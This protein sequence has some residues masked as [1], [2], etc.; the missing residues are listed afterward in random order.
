MDADRW[1]RIDELLGAAMDLAPEDRGRFLAQGCGDDH[2]LRSEVEKLLTAHE[3]AGK[4]I[5][6]SAMKVAARAVAGETLHTRTRKMVG[7]YRIVS[8]L[9]AGGM[10]EVYLAEDTRLN[11]RIALKILPFP[12]VADLDRVRRFEME[13]RAAS[14]L[15]H[16]NIVTIYDV[17]E[18]DSI[19]YIATEYVDGE[20][21]RTRLNSRRLSLTEAIKVGL[22]ITEALT[23]AHE[24]GI[25]HRDVKPENI[26]LRSDGYLKVLDFGLAKLTVEQSGS[27][28]P[29]VETQSGQVFGTIKYMSPEQALGQLVNHRTDLWSTGV[30][31][32]E[33][34]TGKT[35]FSGATQAATFD[36]I[37]N[38]QP[39]PASELNSTLPAALDSIISRSLEK[40]PELR[41]QTAADLRAD[42]RRLQREL[43]PRASKLGRAVRRIGRA[44][45][46][47]SG[48]PAKAVLAAGVVALLVVIAPWV[49]SIREP[50]VRREP[51]PDWASA[52]S[53]KLT[54]EAGPE[55][56]PNLTPDGKG[57]IYAS[58]SSGNWDIVWQRVGGKNSINL[59][60][61]SLADDTQPAYSPDGNYIA[62]R[63]ERNPGGG[64]YVMEA[65]SENVKRI[66][67]LGQNPSWSPDGKKVVVSVDSISDPTSRSIIP[68]ALWIIEVESQTRRLLTEGDAVQ[69]S[70]SPRGDQIAYWGMQRGSGQRDI[71]IIPAAGGEPR[72][73]TNDQAFDWN[74]VWSADG[75]YLYF[76]SDR[77]GSMNFWRVSFDE[78]SGRVSGE[79]ESVTTPSAF[80]QHLSFSRDGKRMAYVQKSETGNLQR[81]AFDPVSGKTTSAP[82][83]ITKGTRYVT[84][85][86]VSPD[87]EW[88][89][90]SSQGERQEDIFLVKNDG[91]NPRQLTND[92]FNDRFPR[93][94][95]DG[96]R[97][98]F[99]S[100]RSGRYEVWL[101]N[102]D[103][104]GLQ[105]LT[106]STGPPTFYP[107]WSPDGNQIVYKQRGAPSFLINTNQPGQAQT[108]QQLATAEGA[109]ETFW[110]WSWSPN[111]RQLAGWW[112]DAN[113]A[114]NHII[115][116]SFETQQYEKLTSF[117]NRPSWLHDNRRLIFQNGGRIYVVDSVSKKVQE[118]LSADPYAVQTVCS[119]QDDRM[120]YYSLLR[121]ES[122]IW[123]LN[124]EEPNK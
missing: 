112:R 19:H 42:L 78:T 18:A 121:T 67:D 61:D 56:F 108:P 48:W 116:Y 1:N 2:A 123:L 105:Q 83:S 55:Y 98:A 81:V 25:T 12:F 21:L 99:Y 40:D 29:L 70:W 89:V 109:G 44:R 85:P 53:I 35:P 95:P 39:T 80:S 94:S 5:E 24:A 33:L 62:F 69:P 9:G 117:G 22:Q 60:K 45:P 84:S 79:P 102:A 34:V 120:L 7:P 52:R 110:P 92:A 51:G 111:G 114:D 47:R 87:G 32:Y 49:F 115:V 88:L 104:A 26:V 82:E 30:V 6:T 72:Q 66:A 41:Y 106:H 90:Y 68:S 63:S 16:P 8:L 31:L 97:I 124:L 113:G 28:A 119:T 96:S 75:R 93:W 91:A 73:V 101:I 20:T 23:A 86:D 57:F 118:V 4:F 58:R 15:N 13:A 50:P 77:G 65:T 38:H 76:A 43:E 64:I 14:A 3:Q 37:L 17:G 59:T 100:D 71:W 107:I 74:P 11:R 10:G 103:G 36:E 122:D 46:D 54:T 27:L